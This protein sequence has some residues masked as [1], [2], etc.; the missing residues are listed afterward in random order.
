MSETQNETQEECLEEACLPP[1]LED[2]CLAAKEGPFP[3]EW[4][5][6]LN[7]RCTHCQWGGFVACDHPCNAHQ[8][9]AVNAV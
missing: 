7:A 4:L 9:D 3:E 8:L 6:Q 1:T 2:A 5:D